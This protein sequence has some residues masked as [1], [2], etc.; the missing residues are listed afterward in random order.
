MWT[1]TFQATSIKTPW[2]EKEPT[3]CKLSGH[4]ATDLLAVRELTRGKL[5]VITHIG[6]GTTSALRARLLSTRLIFRF[7]YARYH[8]TWST[9]LA[10]VTSGFHGQA[11]VAAGLN[12][13]GVRLNKLQ[14][15][16]MLI[17]MACPGVTCIRDCGTWSDWVTYGDVRSA[18]KTNPEGGGAAPRSQQVQ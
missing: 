1:L 7:K 13:F 4:S 15:Y 9:T 10:E 6:Y 3:C 17:L 16:R 2:Y 8:S 18:T 14:I 11:V 12:E 5:D